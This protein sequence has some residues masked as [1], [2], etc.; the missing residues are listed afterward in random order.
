MINFTKAT[1]LNWSKKKMKKKAFK[2]FTQ[3]IL[4]NGKKV[5]QTIWQQV[6]DS[7]QTKKITKMKVRF[8]CCK[9]KE[10]NGEVYL[11]FKPKDLEAE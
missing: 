11:F 9:M 8:D 4:T 6:N 2:K 10:I 3:I 7:L 5:T 1:F